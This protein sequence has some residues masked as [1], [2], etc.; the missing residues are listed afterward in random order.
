MKT[1]TASTHEFASSAK[2]EIQ[3]ELDGYAAGVS[4]QHVVIERI[5]VPP[6]VNEAIELVASAIRERDRLILDSRKT[7]TAMIPDSEK[8]AADI[9]TEANL[10]ASEILSKT[11][12]EVARFEAA[13]KSYRSDPA[14]VV[15]S[16]HH[17][18]L[19]AALPKA[20]SVIM[21][22][23]NDQQGSSVILF[24]QR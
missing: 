13:Y 14:G 10:R 17:G 23:E 4:L 18:M 3:R 1:P 11:R 2:A 16:L 12:G 9:V 8:R 5:D 20:G 24:N 22:P 21:A 15:E 19:R 6:E 7:A